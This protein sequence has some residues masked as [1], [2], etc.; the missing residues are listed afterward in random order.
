M[1]EIQVFYEKDIRKCFPSMKHRSAILFV[2]RAIID[3]VNGSVCLTDKNGIRTSLPIAN[4]CAILLE[5]GISI[6]HEAIKL[7]SYCG[8]L[9]L[10][11]GEN[12]CRLYSSGRTYTNSAKN[13]ETQARCFSNDCTKLEVARR[14]Y[15]FIFGFDPPKNRSIEQLR[16]V[17]GNI[18]R[19]NYKILSKK[20]GIE[21]TGRKY[22]VENSNNNDFI[23]NCINVA[24]TCLYGIMEVGVLISGYSPDLGFIHSG[25]TGSFI[26]DLSDIFKFSCATVPAFQVAAQENEE[27]YSQ[28]VRRLC[29]SKFKEHKILQK[30]IPIINAI[31][32]GI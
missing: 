31:F 13:I 8:C 18:V 1:E 28:L 19:K 15:K 2:R 16:G 26:H 21:W 11:V 5:P 27:K 4:I 20:Y 14:L 32:D 22:D 3:V 12:G 23:N 10:W 30:T 29:V 7:I 25:H 6:T 24:N 9:I 17:E